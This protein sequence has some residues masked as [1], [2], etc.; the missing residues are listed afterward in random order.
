MNSQTLF[1]D[2]FYRALLMKSKNLHNTIFALKT[3]DI[4]ALCQTNTK[5]PEY[6]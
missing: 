2:R 6:Q 4:H 1:F 5:E 3:T